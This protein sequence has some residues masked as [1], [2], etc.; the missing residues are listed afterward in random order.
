VDEALNRP[1]DIV[2]LGP[3]GETV[4]LIRLNPQFSAS[5]WGTMREYG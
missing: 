5:T 4:R 2:A 1:P 3:D